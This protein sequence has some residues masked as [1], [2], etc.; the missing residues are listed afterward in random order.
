M[1]DGRKEA[2]EN[3]EVSNDDHTMVG[4]ELYS[5]QGFS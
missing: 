4:G 5:F 1:V 3:S 2:T